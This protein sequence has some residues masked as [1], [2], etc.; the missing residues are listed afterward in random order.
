MITQ[1]LLTS[2][3]LGGAGGQ[4]GLADFAARIQNYLDVRRVAAQTVPPLA[5]TGDRAATIAA[6]DALAAAIARARAGARQGDIFTPQI[7]AALRA[8][9]ASGCGQRFDELRR[10]LAEDT[11]VPLPPPAINARWPIGAPLPTMTPD[12]LRAL[13]TLPPEL[14]YRFMGRALALRDIDANLILDFV[15]DAIPDNAQVSPARLAL[16]SLPPLP[17]AM[18]G[19]GQ[20][21]VE[22]TID[23]EGRVA[24]SRPLRSSAPLT[25]AVTDAVR[26]WRFD[27]SQKTVDII[28]ESLRLSFRMPRV[29]KVFVGA[30]FRAPAIGVPTLGTPPVERGKPDGETPFPLAVA[31]PA[32]PPMAFGAGVVLVEFTIEADGSVSDACVIES[33]P[34]F[35]AAA[36]DAARRFRFRPAVVD[37]IP[38]AAYAYV[39]FGFPLPITHENSR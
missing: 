3:L 19:G 28:G 20:V 5:V 33:A 36:L 32:F 25:T 21:F 27:P 6:S 7:A 29:S 23:T 16:A 10:D 17:V 18:L 24:D 38:V 2:A 1:L 26:N 4:Q 39:L 8:A 22:L 9:V 34:P 14:E 15:N 37:G 35:D 30:V 11:T 12:V 31:T 13:P